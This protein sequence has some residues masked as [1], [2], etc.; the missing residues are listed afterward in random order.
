MP[1]LVSHELFHALLHPVMDGVHEGFESPLEERIAHHS[2]I[3]L[4]RQF[5]V[6]GYRELMERNGA[7]IDVPGFFDG[8]IVDQ[9]V[10]LMRAAMADPAIAAEWPVEDPA[11]PCRLMIEKFGET[12]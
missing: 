4:C 7:I 6:E 2:A 12:V 10:D 1:L 8:P 9:L 5:G 3:R 11:E